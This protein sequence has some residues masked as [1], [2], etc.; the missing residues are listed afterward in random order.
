[1]ANKLL[2]AHEH[3]CF[4]S[5]RMN[6]HQHPDLQVCTNEKLE[7]VVEGKKKFAKCPTAVQPALAK[8]AGLIDKHGTGLC[9]SCG[10]STK[11]K[12]G[13]RR[14]EVHVKLCTDPTIHYPELYRAGNLDRETYEAWKATLSPSELMGHY[15][16]VP[17]V[18]VVANFTHEETALRETDRDAFNELLNERIRERAEAHLLHQ[19]QYRHSTETCKVQI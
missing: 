17:D 7:I 4:H 9:P 11:L 2:E 14:A 18:H 8:R 19:V 1:M 3:Y 10:C 6:I 13:E 15:K 5:A 12:P 16:R